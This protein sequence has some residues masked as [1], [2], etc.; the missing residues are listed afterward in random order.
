M[1]KV[2]TSIFL[3]LCIST[4][5]L[6]SAD[7][8]LAHWSFDDGTA[9][10]VTGNGY[11]GVK[12]NN[13]T[14]VPGVV[15]N[16][17]HFQGKGYYMRADDN[18][19]NI[20]DHILLP[21]IDL[22]ELKEFTISMWVYEEDFSYSYGD[23]YL[24][25]GHLERYWL[26][27]QNHYDQFNGVFQ[28]LLQFAVNGYRHRTNVL[29]APFELAF[30]KHWVCYVMVFQDSVLKGYINGVLIGSIIKKVQYSMEHFALCRS[31]W[32]YEGEERTSARFTGAIDEVKI[33]K[34]A[35]TD[36]EVR[37]E[38]LS[39]GPMSFSYTSFQ[40]IPSFRLLNNAG[41]YN[42]AIRLTFA[43]KNQVGAVWTGHLVPVAFGFET[44]FRFRISEGCNPNHKEEHFPGADGIAFVIQNSSNFALGNLGGGIGYDGIPNSVAIEFD[45]YANDSTQIENYYDPNDNH[46]AVLSNGINPNSSKHILPYIRGQTTKIPPLKTDS[47]VYY[48][49]IR[50][51]HFN[52]SLSVWLDTVENFTDPKLVVNG[53]DLASELSLEDGEGAFIGFTSAT[54]SSYEN[55]DILA[56]SF[57]PFSR[58]IY[59]S[60]EKEISPSDFVSHIIIENKKLILP[61]FFRNNETMFFKIY[62]FS[63]NELD[64]NLLIVK[65]LYQYLYIENQGLG[66][67]V[68]ILVFYLPFSSEIHPFLI[69][70]NN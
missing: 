55:H 43:T 10:D 61:K 63:G 62:S 69:I 9:R 32:N 60:S 59:S 49:M 70:V 23:A 17:L 44:T 22:H 46:I 31:W 4:L 42:N 53:F 68:Y 64:T 1:T 41:I 6:S 57:C 11:D 47:T 3:L 2:F 29:I 56:W 16:A 37:N 13:P 28:L 14:I 12:M 27:I 66:N 35:L 8:L 36:D 40:P 58:K 20:G 52:K 48:A 65:N 15:G 67:G 33:F 7:D 5:K 51:D 18:P 25:F 34:R 50:Y 19:A 24:F 26:G 30:R 54:G 21:P 45:T 38:C 39:C